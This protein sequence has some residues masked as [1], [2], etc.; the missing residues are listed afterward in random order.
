MGYSETNSSVPVDKQKTAREVVCF[1]PGEK[2]RVRAWLRAEGL[3]FS[4]EGYAHFM[5]RVE[6]WE[7]KNGIAP[8]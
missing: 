5:P 7:K 6:A 1:S 8:A 2:E 3:A 4:S